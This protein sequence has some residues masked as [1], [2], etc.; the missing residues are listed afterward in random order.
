MTGALWVALLAGLDFE[1]GSSRVGEGI[2]LR[3]RGRAR[4]LPDGAAVRLRF[5]RIVNRVEGRRITARPE[6]FFR[7]RRAEVRKEWF[8][9]R[10]LFAAPADVEVEAAVDPAE[11]ASDQD[12]AATT[13]VVRIGSPWDA[14]PVLRREIRA[15]EGWLQEARLYGG[16]G[17]RERAIRRLASLREEEPAALFTA[18]VDRLA[19]VLEGFLST[20]AREAEAPGFGGRPLGLRPQDLP[21]ALESV[22]E[23]FR[24]ERVILLVRE[25]VRVRGTDRA[26]GVLVSAAEGDESL[27]VLLH[28]SAGEGFE[29]VAAE[30]E[31]RFREGL[32]GEATTSRQEVYRK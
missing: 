25:A 20:G 6:A 18:T 5:R 14:A 22:A 26:L 9:H 29:R 28:G 13:R 19:G 11:R 15:L 23:V 1:A 16:P 17:G 7:V 27:Q 31:W 30:V 12:S 24:R 8:S 10:E 4:G 3:I 21:G 2:E 32:G